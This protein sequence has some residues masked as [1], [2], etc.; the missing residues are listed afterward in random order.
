MLMV[1]T[2]L[3]LNVRCF[4]IFYYRLAWHA[5]NPNFL[6][7]VYRLMAFAPE[8]LSSQRHDHWSQ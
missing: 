8:T 4:E 5:N 3:I 7:A 6:N 1:T 2:Q